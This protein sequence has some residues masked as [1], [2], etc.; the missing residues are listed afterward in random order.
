MVKIAGVAVL[1]Q[2]M[3]QAC[4]MSQQIQHVEFLTVFFSCRIT[5]ARVDTHVVFATC[6]QHDNNYFQN[7]RITITSKKLLMWPWLNK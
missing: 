4:T 7:N 3:R 1:A 5:S 6:L 2:A